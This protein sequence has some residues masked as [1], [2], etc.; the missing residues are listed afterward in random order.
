[1]GKKRVQSEK[2]SLAGTEE[3]GTKVFIE[4]LREKAAVTDEEKSVNTNQMAYSSYICESGS[5]E[6][7]RESSWSHKQ[8][9]VSPC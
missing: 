9:N 8:L 3:E 4:F 6:C 7:T 5:W 2:R 1:M